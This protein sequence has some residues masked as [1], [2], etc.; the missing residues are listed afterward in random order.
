MSLIR[1][2]TE[3]SFVDDTIPPIDPLDLPSKISNF[4]FL[5]LQLCFKSISINSEWLL[6]P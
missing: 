4:I 1:M 5:S 3:R 6:L 2:R